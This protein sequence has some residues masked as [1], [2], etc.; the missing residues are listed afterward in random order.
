MLFVCTG[1]TCRSP[2]AV[3]LLKKMF[4]PDTFRILSAGTGA[5]EGLQPSRYAME[6]MR[7]EDVDI[8][9]HRSRVL[10]ADLLEEAD[11]VLVM[12]ESHRRQIADWFKSYASK[13]RLLREFDPV[14]DDPDYPN[15][16]D[17][18]G[19]GKDAY[20]KCKDMIER[21]LERAIKEL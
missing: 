11:K 3:G 15:V 1:N 18:I 6:V 20:I 12:A 14:R 16:P 9:D 4:G 5:A 21:S 8:S 7:D 19:L 17:P 10:H 2:M 13:T